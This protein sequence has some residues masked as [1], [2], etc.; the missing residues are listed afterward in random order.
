MS[1]LTR[2]CHH[3]SYRSRNFKL[4]LGT[5]GYAKMAATSPTTINPA[6]AAELAKNI[7]DVKQRMHQACSLQTRSSESDQT[8]SEGTKPRYPT[9]VA[10]SK[11]KPASDILACYEHGQRD[12]GENYV[13]ELIDKS[14]VVRL[15]LIYFD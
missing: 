12:F 8:E 7:S 10:V 3:F 9:L 1:F 4:L 13:Q 14:K 5:R 15:H 6:R 2:A 11:Y